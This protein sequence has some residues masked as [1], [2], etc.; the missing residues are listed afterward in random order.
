MSSF[1]GLKLKD[2]KKD[3]GFAIP[4]IL[5][6]GIGIAISVTGL[7]AA[8]ILGLTGSRISRQELLAKSSAYSGISRLRTLFND[9]TK[10]R[11]FNYFWL[12]NNCSE[13]ASECESINIASPPTE[14]WSDDSWCNGEENCNGRQKAPFCSLDNNY[15]WEDE[16]QIVSNLFSESNII[17][18][19]FGDSERDF[20]QQY[21]IISSKYIGT[22][23]YGINSILIEGLS[24][25]KNSNIK[26]GSNKLRVNIQ[27]NGETAESGFGFIGVGENNSDKFESLY[28]GNLNVNKNNNSKGSIIWRMNIENVDNC[29]NFIELAKT[30]NALL[31]SGGNGGLW[32]QP[33]ALPKQPRLKNVRD[34][35][36]LICTSENYAKENSNCR[37][38]S[39]DSYEKTFRIYS[40]FSRGPGSRFE[41]STEDNKKIILEIMGDI[42][43]SNEGRFCHRDGLNPCGSGKPENLTILFKQKS[44]SKE[45]KLVCNKDSDFGGV[46]INNNFSYNT[47]SSFNNDLLP[48]HTFLIDNTGENLNEE[49]GAFVYGPKTTLLS[50]RLKSNWI[51]IS[52]TQQIA[53]NSGLIVIS[54]GVYGYIANVNGDSI[55]DK[56]TNL[57]LTSDQKLIPYGTE[58]DLNN[59]EIIGVGEKINSLPANSQ[60]DSTISKV[61]LMFDNIT[62]NYHLRGFD[63]ININRLNNSNLQNSYPGSFAILRPKNNLNDIN[64][65]DTLSEN[66]FS[67]NYLRAFNIEV[68]ARENYFDRNFSGAAWVKNFCFDNIGQKNWKFSENFID[69]LVSWHGSE[70]NWGVK[71]YRGK[72]II[73]WDTLRDFDSN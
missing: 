35:G 17:G 30:N 5:I 58:N 43:I 51:Q 47:N 71:Y 54:R 11:L 59:L 44:E 41:V 67:N 53:N 72:S 28:L 73:L 3:K 24:K 25:P 13:D 21:K 60:F 15:S 39:G 69:R 42:D 50:K 1:S 45:N 55:E 20:E 4:Q 62:S 22:E 56:I 18:D 70:F 57:I 2:I 66:S 29:G 12:V 34:I 37:L 6:L 10:G 14:Y 36:T 23:E 8:S 61:F 49:F 32:V 63:S 31:P 52:N 40:L 65:G 64:L 33:L 27:V 68:K 38:D 46:K 7:I 48:G 19:V 26:S 9:N 16:Q